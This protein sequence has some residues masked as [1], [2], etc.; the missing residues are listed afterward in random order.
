MVAKIQKNDNGARNRIFWRMEDGELR[1]EKC[2]Y[3]LI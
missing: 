2:Y 1:M 3:F